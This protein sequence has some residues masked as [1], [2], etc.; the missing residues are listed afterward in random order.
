MQ[1]PRIPMYSS[2][3]ARK[4]FEPYDQHLWDVVREKIQFK[5]LI[6]LMQD[7]KESLFIDLSAS[8]TLGNFIKYGFDK[9]IPSLFAINQ[10]GQDMKTLGN[11]F[12]CLKK[13][14][15]ANQSIK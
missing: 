5:K 1:P 11:L 12:F 9:K 14:Q 10:F 15:V 7:E 4:V 6:S 2:V 3:K 8:G 13:F